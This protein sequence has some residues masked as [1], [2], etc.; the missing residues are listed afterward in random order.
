M[1]SSEFL[2][3]DPATAHLARGLTKEATW[4]MEDDELLQAARKHLREWRCAMSL[5]SH[6]SS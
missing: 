6:K 5:S 1:G 4:D 3:V 2:D